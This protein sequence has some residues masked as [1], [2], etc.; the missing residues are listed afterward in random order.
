MCHKVVIAALYSSSMH[1]LDSYIAQLKVSPELAVLLEPLFELIEEQARRIQELEAE[2]AT[3]RAQLEQNS[4][5]SHKPPASDGYRKTPAIPKK[6]GKKGGQPGHRG[7]TLRMVEV[8]DVIDEQAPETC[9][10]CGSSLTEVAP[11]A[12]ERTLSSA[13]RSST[14]PIPA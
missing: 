4:R 1:D 12:L 7:H 2:V 3:L 10:H 14:F 13:G 6:A 11:D 5:N 9:T 8:P